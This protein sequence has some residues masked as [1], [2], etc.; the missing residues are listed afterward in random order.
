MVDCRCGANTRS[1]IQTCTNVEGNTCNIYHDGLKPFVNG[2]ANF[3]AAASDYQSTCKAYGYGQYLDNTYTPVYGPV[4]QS[5]KNTIEYDAG[6]SVDDLMKWF[7]GSNQDSPCTSGPQVTE[8]MFRQY[9]GDPSRNDFSFAREDD[10]CA[11][12]NVEVKVVETKCDKTCG[13]GTYTKTSTCF[14]KGGDQD[15]KEVSEVSVYLTKLKFLHAM[16]NAVI[17]GT[18]VITI[19][20]TPTQLINCSLQGPLGFQVLEI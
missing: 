6:T 4:A 1:R 9:L 13:C 10:S 19:H 16:F 14:Y 2:S 11:A 18:N 17:H 3:D 15:G 8:N 12:T 5:L 7:P 20:V